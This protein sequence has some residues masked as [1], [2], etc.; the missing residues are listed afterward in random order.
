VSRLSDLARRAAK[1]LPGKIASRL[2][3]GEPGVAVLLYHRVVPVVKDDRFSLQVSEENFREQMRWLKSRYPVLPLDRAIGD[4]ERGTLPERH[5]VSLT[6]DDGY[7]DNLTRALPILE[8]LDLP[9]TFFISTGFVM[10]GKP[11]WWDRL[12]R[13]GGASAPPPGTKPNEDPYSRAKGLDPHARDAWLD[14]LGLPD[15]PFCEEELPLRSSELKLLGPRAT[16]G[17]H[18]HEHLSLGLVSRQVAEADVKMCAEALDRESGSRPRL[19]AYPFGGPQDV[20]PDAVEVV[21]QAGFTA[22][23]TTAP[24]VLRRGADPLRFPRLWVHDGPA[25]ALATRLLRA[26]VESRQPVSDGSMT[27]RS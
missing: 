22:A 9:A 2:L 12:A 24:L 15:P 26:F 18:G 3:Q 6:F 10:S 23:F 27:R 14:G 8:E 1:G 25:G 21:R 16:I 5:V 4:L 7:R 11:F 20:S 13:A 19:F 17:G